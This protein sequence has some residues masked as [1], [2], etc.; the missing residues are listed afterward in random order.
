MHFPLYLTFSPSD[1]T[2]SLSS[3]SLSLSLSL[4]SSSG[5]IRVD[6]YSFLIATSSACSLKSPFPLYLSDNSLYVLDPIVAHFNSER[7]SGIFDLEFSIDFENQYPLF[8]RLPIYGSTSPYSCVG[9]LFTESRPDQVL[10]TVYI[11][12]TAHSPLQP[13]LDLTRWPMDRCVRSK[14]LC[15]RLSPLSALFP[16]ME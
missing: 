6:Y 1:L 16:H 10:I 9:F 4:S 8:S 15:S 7:L 14:G 12:P 5:R 3:L 13:R 2:F 11:H